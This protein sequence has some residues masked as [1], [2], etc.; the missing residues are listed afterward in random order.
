M[1]Q[2]TNIEV[3]VALLRAHMHKKDLA[4]LLDMDGK[5][6][7]NRFYGELPQDL[8]ERL[9][10]LIQ[11]VA[12]CDEP[13]QEDL[14]NYRQCCHQMKRYSDYKQ[15]QLNERTIA[16]VEF[17]EKNGNIKQKEIN[18]LS[19]KFNISKDNPTFF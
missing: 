17:V 3:Q 11:C 5:T 15:E 16:F 9:I 19:E 14:E 18:D 2:L 8:Q 10:K 6:F 4:K 12:Y 13:T 7:R 1:S